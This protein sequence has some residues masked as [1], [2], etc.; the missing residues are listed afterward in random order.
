MSSP[1]SVDGPVV[2]VH[3]D[4]VN[5]ADA[6]AAAAANGATIVGSKHVPRGKVFFTN[7]S[8]LRFKS[9]G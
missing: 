8:T 3:P 9:R 7:G 5:L 1:D 2:L 6:K 4:D